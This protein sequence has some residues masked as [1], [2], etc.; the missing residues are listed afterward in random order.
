[1]SVDRRRLMIQPMYLKESYAKSKCSVNSIRD[2]AV[3]MH[4]RHAVQH[5]HPSKS[6]TIGVALQ[7][8]CC[9]SALDAAVI[10]AVPLPSR[11]AAQG[12]LVSW[13]EGRK[14]KSPSYR[15]TSCDVDSTR[16]SRPV[17][18][19]SSRLLGS[20]IPSG[21]HAPSYV[22]HHCRSAVRTA[23][24]Q[25]KHRPSCVAAGHPSTAQC[26]RYHAVRVA[27]D[28]HAP[29]TIPISLQDPSARTASRGHMRLVDGVVDAIALTITSKLFLRC[30]H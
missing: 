21:V 26:K 11:G 22:T 20:H 10:A 24:S 30:C 6:P 16:R 4:A 23:E 1:M 25:H 28:V 15:I 8:G 18:H 17:L 3:L 27:Q 29:G 12:G 14:R 5:P 9:L 13:A 2:T 7:P 19:G